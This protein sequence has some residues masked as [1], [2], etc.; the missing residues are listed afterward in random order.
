M[1]HKKGDILA[2]KPILEPCTSVL[3]SLDILRGI[4]GGF[5]S[6]VIAKIELCFS[7]ERFGLPTRIAIVHPGKHTEY[8]HSEGIFN[9]SL[10]T[11]EHI[12]MIDNQ[13]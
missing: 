12:A 2:Q 6:V 11:S 13:L 7:W 5:T 10:L 1:S 9:Q 3:L 4:L 8:H